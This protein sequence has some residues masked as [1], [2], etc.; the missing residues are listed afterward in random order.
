MKNN[1]KRNKRGQF[2]PGNKDA[3]KWTEVSVMQRLKKSLKLL[4]KDE[5]EEG[6]Y[7]I[8][9]IVQLSKHLGTYHQWFGLMKNKFKDNELINNT[10]EQIFTIC[11]AR[12]FEMTAEGKINPYVGQFGLKIYHN[13]RETQELHQKTESSGE[14][15]VILTKKTKNNE[16]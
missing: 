4:S 6:K 1:R 2:V 12:L 16:E 15:T 13:R 8:Y 7:K 10:I 5:N 14:M 9:S 3:E 11:E